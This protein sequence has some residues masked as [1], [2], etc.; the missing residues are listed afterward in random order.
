MIPA[1]STGGRPRKM[2]QRQPN[3]Q[4]KRPPRSSIMATER[5]KAD[6]ERAHV[7][8][9]PHRQG[10]D[11]KFPECALGRLV[12]SRKLHEAVYDA[13]LE[14]AGVCRRYGAAWGAPISERVGEGTGSAEGPSLSTVAA[15][16]SYLDD[17]EDAMGS[18]YPAVRRVIVADVDPSPME[19]ASAITG[20]IALARHLGKLDRRQHPFGG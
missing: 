15:W 7:K 17:A 2:V 10:D 14:Y 16:K 9:Q 12:K 1:T 3:G 4:P 5:E 20:L 18:D 19:V 8:Y 11:S 13:G 6:R